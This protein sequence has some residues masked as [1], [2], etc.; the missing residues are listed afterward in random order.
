MA[1]ETVL[2]AQKINYHSIELGIVVLTDILT[3]S[4]QEKLNKELNHYQL[5]LMTDR[6]KILVER[7]KTEILNLLQSSY[8]M[9][10]KLSA[11]LSMMLGYNY[12]YLANVFAEQE[13]MTLEKYFIMQRVERV[14][15]LIVYEDLSL[16]QI[17]KQLHYSSISHLS[18][19]FK[20]VTGFTLTDFKKRCQFEDFIWRSC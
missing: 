5:E 6:N 3:S 1:V 4:Q 20:K 19:Q 10:L 7:V 13:E 12:T 8:N 16:S 9:P 11:F 14:K 15:E 17:T 18:V 2:E